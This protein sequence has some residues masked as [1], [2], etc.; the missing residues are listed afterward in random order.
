MTINSGTL[1]I[2]ENGT[3]GTLGANNVSNQAALVFNR[4]DTITD[5]GVISGSGSLTQIGDGVLILTNSHS[6]FGPT[7]IQSGTLAIAGNGAIANSTNVMLSEGA[8]LDVSSH[9]GGNVTLASGQT[10]S[11]NGNVRG[12]LIFASG[13]K[14]SPG[15]SVGTLTFSN[16]LTLAAGS[17]TQL[18]ISKGPLANDALT[19]LGTF[20]YG[21]NLVVTNVS[22]NALAGGDS[23][24]LWN[25]ATH[26][27]AFASLLLPPLGTNLVWDTNA[28]LAS[29]TLAVVSTAPPMFGNMT[30][31]V[32][33]N[34]RLSFSG[35]AGRDYELRATTNLALTP[36]TLWD[37]VASGTF[38]NG[39]VTFDDSNATN[40][41]QRYYRLVVP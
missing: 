12:N 2:G 41:P 33:G 9:A 27:G 18:E 10:L 29:G 3:G 30:S 15:N 37:L 5:S 39:A 38:S 32:D 1:Q 17:S 21:G 35:P 13:A 34:F 22:G 11:G 19:V 7:L 14:L 23:F 40:F 20:T 25:A 16:A 31:L 26:S 36:V 8:L 6:Y 28:F 4:A 24:V